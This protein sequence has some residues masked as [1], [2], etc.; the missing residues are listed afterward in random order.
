MVG[1]DGLT[2]KSD[3]LATAIAGRTSLD[4]AKTEEILFKCED[5]IRGEP[6]NQREVVMLVAA[7]RELETKLGIG[8]SAKTKI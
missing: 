2:A 8:R 5:I 3:Q 4:R 1:L 7:L 6:T